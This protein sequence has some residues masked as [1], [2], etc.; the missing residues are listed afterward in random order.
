M[1]MYYI[2]PVC[3]FY[4]YR[5]SSC[6]P[7]GRRLKKKVKFREDIKDQLALSYL[8]Y[9]VIW[10]GLFGRLYHLEN[11]GRPLM[12]LA[13]YETLFGLT[14]PNSYSIGLFIIRRLGYRR[15]YLVGT[16]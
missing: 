4:L 14:H 1:G 11:I 9:L 5:K 6:T 12:S 16:G 2:I 8:S 13:K 3:G 15:F 7:I 10:L